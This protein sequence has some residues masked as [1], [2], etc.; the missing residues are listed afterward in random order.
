MAILQKK[1]KKKLIINQL[2][3]EKSRQQVNFTRSL[4]FVNKN[5]LDLKEKDI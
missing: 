2:D 4:Q 3:L 1:D 5:E